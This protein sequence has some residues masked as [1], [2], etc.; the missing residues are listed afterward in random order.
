MG[1]DGSLTR[2]ANTYPIFL[3]NP[4]RLRYGVAVECHER[5]ADQAEDSVAVWRTWPKHD[6]SRGLLGR[7]G[8]DIREVEIQRQK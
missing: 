5:L 8:A 7:I 4:Q 6:D 3:D 1:L 2:P